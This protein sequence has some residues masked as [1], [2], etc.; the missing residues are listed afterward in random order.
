VCDGDYDC[1][2]ASDEYDCDHH[3]SHSDCHPEYEF[4]VR[5]LK[6]VL[7]QQV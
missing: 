6:L 3:L 7:A 2:D 4:Q 1:S 5:Q